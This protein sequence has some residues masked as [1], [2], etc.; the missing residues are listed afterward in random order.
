MTDLACPKCGST[1]FVPLKAT[2]V[3]RRNW[4][5]VW[6]KVR[7]ADTAGCEACRRVWQIH[8]S[9][10]ILMVEDVPPPPKPQLVPREDED[11]DDTPRHALA[12]AVRRPEV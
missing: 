12:D 4:R 3:Y 8:D 11:E 7:I 2:F 9:G 6:R 1:R 5:G 10:A